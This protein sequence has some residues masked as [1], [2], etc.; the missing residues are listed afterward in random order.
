M[1]DQD[2]AFLGYRRQVRAVLPVLAPDALVRILTL[3]N[4]PDIGWKHFDGDIAQYNIP[5]GFDVDEAQRVALAGFHEP[6]HEY[7]EYLCRLDPQKRHRQAFLTLIG[8]TRPWDELK[9]EADA[10][11]TPNEQHAADPG[12]WWADAGADAI[13]GIP[14]V[15]PFAVQ[16][17]APATFLAFFRSLIATPAPIPP[18]PDPVP[19]PTVTWDDLRPIP[20][21]NYGG[22]RPRGVLGIV[23]H[24]MVGTIESADA[25]F[26]NPAAIASATFGVGLS[27]RIVLWV[28]VDRIAYHAGNWTINEERVGI[29]HED[30]GAYWD[31]VRTPELYLASGALHRWLADEYG[32]PLDD[33]HV[34]PHLRFAATACPDALDIPRIIAIAQGEVMYV[35]TEDFQR[36]QQDVAASFASVKAL[37]NPLAA[38]AAHAP[39]LPRGSELRRH[40]RR[41]ELAARPPKITRT[42]ARRA[43]KPAGAPTRKQVLAGHGKGR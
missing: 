32:F 34:G 30:D 8:E 18:T 39:G 14:K 16:N 3:P 27:G 43:K 21:S 35:S 31:A 41:I 4:E 19:L 2:A 37:L 13:A 12:E 1:I 7:E 20:S 10:K 15:G 36:Y 26:S 24:T 23:D 29:E 28:D 17:V 42:T 38:G 11:P 40:V 9:A 25:R 33:A 22:P 5:D 6:L